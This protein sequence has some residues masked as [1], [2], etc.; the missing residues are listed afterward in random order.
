MIKIDGI[1]EERKYSYPNYMKLI[2]SVCF[3]FIFIA[4][5]Y[6]LIKYPSGYWFQKWFI[7]PTILVF[8]SIPALL[9]II[10]KTIIITNNQIIAKSL[11]NKK[12][13]NFNDI[14]DVK[15]PL[16]KRNKLTAFQFI[17]KNGDKHRIYLSG[18]MTDSIELFY[19]LNL[20]A[21]RIKLD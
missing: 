5:C 6:T 9:S 13:I 11:F 21:D 2:L 20:I 4:D 16:T 7:L 19:Y 12:V 10:M 14:H 17:M 15:K 3:L 18:D 1:S 8:A